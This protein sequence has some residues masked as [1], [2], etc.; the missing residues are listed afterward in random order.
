M[1]R[2]CCSTCL[3]DSYGIAAKPS[4]SG[5]KSIGVVYHSGYGHATSKRWFKQDWKDRIA[6]G[7]TRSAQINGDKHF[8]LH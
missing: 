5:M 2:S 6:A 7:L 4:K 1:L 3:E 8:T